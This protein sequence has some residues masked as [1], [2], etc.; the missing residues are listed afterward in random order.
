MSSLNSRITTLR[1]SLSLGVSWPSSSVQS[2][3]STAN[4]RI[5]SAWET[6]VGLV[7]GCVDLGA[8]VRVFGELRDRVGLAV[9][10]GPRR[11]PP[12]DRG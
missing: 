8:Q 1:L 3:G 12:G 9:R 6:A 5:D 11:E 7:D 2:T 4:L 10:G